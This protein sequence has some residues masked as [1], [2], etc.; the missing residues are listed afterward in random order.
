MS[1][2]SACSSKKDLPPLQTVDHVDIQKFMGSWNVIANIPTI[3]EKGAF[4]AIENYKWNEEKK[5]IDVKFTF[6]ADSFD[7]ERKEYPQKAFIHN[8]DTNAEWRIQF[9]WPLKFAYL[10]LHVD[11]AYSYCVIGVPDRDHVW[12]MSREK[13]MNETLYQ[14]LIADLKMKGFDTSLIQKVPQKI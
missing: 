6:N 11:E 12:I 10:I 4:N 7:G 14:K 8:K 9:F 5:R 13:T 3:I 2:F 1:L